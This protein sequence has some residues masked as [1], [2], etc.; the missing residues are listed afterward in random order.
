M[1][2]SPPNLALLRATLRPFRYEVLEASNIEQGLAL[3]RKHLPDVIIS[4]LHLQRE[5]GY[6]FL[7][8]IKADAALKA[9]KFI[10]LSSTVWRTKDQQHGLDLGA[11]RFLLRPI[12][13]QALLA[14]IEAC[15]NDK[16]N[17]RAHGHDPDH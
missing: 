11:D 15:L 1:D 5:S 12:E 2:N 7:K 3:A 9:I 14:E 17:G 13:P 8:T 16:K 4:D 10:Y 6:D